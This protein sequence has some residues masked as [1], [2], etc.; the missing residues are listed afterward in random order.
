MMGSRLPPPCPPPAV[1]APSVSGHFPS[2]AACCAELRNAPR[3][4]PGSPGYPG[5]RPSPRPGPL[6]VPAPSSPALLAA[7]PAAL[8]GRRKR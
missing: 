2:R 6:P 7:G 1:A 5:A 4:S 3:E 8:V